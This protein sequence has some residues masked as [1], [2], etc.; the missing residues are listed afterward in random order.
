LR[1]AITA[2]P[3]DVRHGSALPYSGSFDL[4]APCSW[5]MVDLKIQVEGAAPESKLPHAERRSHS[6]HQAAKP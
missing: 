3:P 6:S 4:A 1:D 2:S 5:L